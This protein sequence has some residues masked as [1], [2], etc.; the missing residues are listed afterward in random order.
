MLREDYLR[1]LTGEAAHLVAAHTMS[2]EEFVAT[3]WSKGE[4]NLT[5]TQ[6]PRQ[7]LVHGHCHQKALVGMGPALYAL[8]LPQNY[9]VSEIPTTCCGM[10]GSNGFE[11]EHYDRS[12]QAAEIILLPTVRGAAPEVEIVAAGISCRQQIAHGAGRRPSHPA[13]VL[14][15]ALINDHAPQPPQSHNP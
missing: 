10:A 12:L 5:F 3:R 1:L 14:R 9:Q 2:L 15:D 4:L 7:V 11:C 13:V 6:Q 8:G